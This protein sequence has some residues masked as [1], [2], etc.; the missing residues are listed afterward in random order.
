M[1]IFKRRSTA[2]LLT[3]CLAS[4]LAVQA[5]AP[6]PPAIQLRARVLAAL[7]LEAGAAQASGPST[8]VSAF[9]VAAD[10]I[11]VEATVAGGSAE[12]VILR[13][14]LTMHANVRTF[15]LR[16]QVT[17]P[18]E[19]TT[20]GQISLE[21]TAGV[22]TSRPLA[23]RDGQVFAMASSAKFPDA[24]YSGS[25]LITIPPAPDGETRTLVV[26]VTMETHSR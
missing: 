20:E 26:L 13:V 23:L 22:I 19:G 10:T 16:A 7:R 12:P 8:G 21:G 5:A 1:N 17:G 4:S 15:L 24:T 3:V 9:S 18:T 14:P 11:R 2:L 25:L 6:A